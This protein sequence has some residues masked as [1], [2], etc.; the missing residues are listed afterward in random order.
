MLGLIRLQINLSNPVYVFT[1]EYFW[2]QIQGVRPELLCFTFRNFEIDMRI[3]M[4]PFRESM[5]IWVIYPIFSSEQLTKKE[6]WKVAKH[7]LKEFSQMIMWKFPLLY[8]RI[9]Y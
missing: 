6:P 3:Y 1:I 2:N 9:N 8:K 4:N 7:S 5:L